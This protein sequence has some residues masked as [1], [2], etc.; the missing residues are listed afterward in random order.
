MDKKAEEQNHVI[1]KSR[2]GLRGG[3]FILETRVRKGNLEGGNKQ[4]K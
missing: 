2:C 3:F 1:P 4:W